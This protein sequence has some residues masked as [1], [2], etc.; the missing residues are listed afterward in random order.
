FLI[1]IMGLLSC[2]AQ[3]IE[4]SIAS[5]GSFEEEIEPG[6]I[7]T[8]ERTIDSQL[9]NTPAFGLI[10]SHHI[11]WTDP[12]IYQLFDKKVIEGIPARSPLLSDTITVQVM[13]VDSTGF[14]YEATCNFA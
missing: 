10:T 7:T 12:C 1:I 2:D 8:Y 3:V 13:T 5:E 14:S 6:V 4:C 9:E 11:H